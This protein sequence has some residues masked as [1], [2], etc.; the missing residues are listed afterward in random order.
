LKK[1]NDSF[2]EDKIQIKHNEK[3]IKD[4][5]DFLKKWTILSEYN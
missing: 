3:L 5:S 4:N 1:L 2:E